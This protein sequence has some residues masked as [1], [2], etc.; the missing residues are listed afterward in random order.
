MESRGGAVQNAHTRELVS[1]SLAIL[2]S[3]AVPTDSPS[4]NMLPVQRWL[5]SGEQAPAFLLNDFDLTLS[6][7]TIQP[8]RHFVLYSHLV[9]RAGR[10]AGRLFVQVGHQTSKTLER[11]CGGEHIQCSTCPNSTVH[12]APGRGGR[13]LVF[14]GSDRRVTESKRYG[15]DLSRLSKHF[16]NGVFASALNREIFGVRVWPVLFTR[17]HLRRLPAAELDSALHTPMRQ[18]LDEKDRWLFAA[19][20]TLYPNQDRSKNCRDCV[21]AVRWLQ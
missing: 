20:G 2:P 11:L 18:L 17:G 12:L 6:H 1:T 3:A 21:D 5:R 9:C 15:V 8:A 14:S 7:A 19:W 16:P 10:P 4:M 13:R